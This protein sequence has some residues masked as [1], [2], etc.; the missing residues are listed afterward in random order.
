MIW[1]KVQILMIK[2]QKKMIKKKFL[3]Y[4]APYPIQWKIMYTMTNM[5]QHYWSMEDLIMYFKYW[6][7]KFNFLFINFS[8]F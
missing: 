6:N 7:F 1:S 2:R 3:C 8:Y 5:D 4:Q